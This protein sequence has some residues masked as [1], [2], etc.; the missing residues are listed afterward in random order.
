MFFENDIIKMVVSLIDNI[1]VLFGGRLFQQE[2]FPAYLSN[3]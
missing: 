2:C 1:F 3:I